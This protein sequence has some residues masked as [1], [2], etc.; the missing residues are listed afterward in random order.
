MFLGSHR[1]PIVQGGSQTQHAHL[2]TQQRHGI[3]KFVGRHRTLFGQAQRSLMPPMG[4]WIPK[5]PGSRKDSCA[6]EL[7]RIRRCDEEER[8]LRG[9]SGDQSSF[10]EPVLSWS[11]QLWKQ[12]P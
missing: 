2:K 5:N 9:E 11:R 4:A 7:R 10:L 6:G 1:L 8:T 3:V 12:L